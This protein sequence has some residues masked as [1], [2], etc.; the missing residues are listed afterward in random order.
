MTTPL[1]TLLAAAAALVAAAPH[2]GSAQQPAAAALDTVLTLGGAARLAAR[3]SAPAE[4]ARARVAQAGARV[5][6]RRDALLPYID[7]EARQTQRT[8]NTAEFGI[9]FP[10]PPGQPPVFAP[11]GEVLGPVNLYDVRGRLSQS[12]ID[13]AAFQRVKAARAAERASDAEATSQGQ[14][15]AG[16]AATAYVRALRADAQL[17]ARVA[18][19]TLAADLLG[20]AQQQLRA[21]TGVAL[22]VTRAQSQLASARASLI[23]ARNERDRARLDL[24]RIIG[25]PLDTRVRLADSLAA[26][27]AEDVPPAE[28]A[29]VQRALAGRA[30]LR[31]AAAQIDAQQRQITALR[32]ERLPSVAAFANTGA[33]GNT[34]GNLKSTYQWGVQASIPVIDWLRADGRVEEQSAVVHEFEVRKRDLE[35][36][37]AV[38][39]RSALLDL[40]S[41]QEQTAAA[42]E[43]L[44][45]AEQEVAQARDRFRAGVAGN[46][47]VI[48]A[49]F[50]LN[51][52]RTAYV[53]AIASYQSARVALARAEGAI[54]ELP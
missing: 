46:A 39:V 22:D 25:L 34:A 5:Q 35:T 27:P 17:S 11:G 31:A 36:Q 43:R 19:S 54:T 42:G 33:I 3:Q 18:D 6:Q 24:S 4:V 16:Q 32:A 2:A 7:L 23:A 30:D 13:P 47:D 20:I 49:S 10:T 52:A 15:A 29:A 38:D 48:T 28:A 9:Q 12:L 51:A 41:T 14:L 8:F 40:R 50:S 37:A 44:R 53:D 1:R 26:P 45:L 21:G